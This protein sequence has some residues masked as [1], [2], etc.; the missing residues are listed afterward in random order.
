[1]IGW[2]ALLCAL[3]LNATANSLL[4][5]GSASVRDGF[6]SATILQAVTNPYLIGGIVLFALNVL[7][8]IVALSKLP[9][10]M[11]YPAM[12]IGGLFIVTIIAVVLF[13][14]SLS[15]VQVAGLAFV[16]FGTVLLYL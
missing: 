8:Y 2:T 4:K 1:M 9:L 12:V 11:T 13:G 10:S 3:V 14:E 6:S 5:A 7:C 16:V 15:Y